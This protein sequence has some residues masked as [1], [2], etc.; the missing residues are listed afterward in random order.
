MN[1]WSPT[2]GLLFV[3]LLWGASFV[4]VKAALELAA[5]LA[6]LSVRFALASA[7]AL[8]LVRR[9]PGV[10][11]AFGWG[12]PL[13][14]VLAASYA[15]QTIGLVETSPSRSAF[16]TGAG[17]VAIP[18]WGLFLL[19]RRPA[20]HTL[21]GLAL[22]VY[23][24]WLIT[25][26]AG[27]SWDTG[28]SWTLACAILFSLHVVLLTRYGSHETFSLL[29]SQLLVTAILTGG[30]SYWLEPPPRI[31]WSGRLIAMIALTGIGVSFLATLLQIRLQSL[32]TPARTA[33][34]FATEPVFAALTSMLLL[35]ER[36]SWIG[37]I[38]GGLVVS[39]VLLSELGVKSVRPLPTIPESPA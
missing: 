24:I 38:G 4:V 21:L 39:G 37:W 29:T 6:F 13:G 11:A 34:V 25:D 18:L 20:P 28:D 32:L 12:V 7:F 1:R 17:V 2:A 5:P 36:M 8:L 15:A 33:V 23:G 27:G 30:L 3:S 10:R 22:A 14:A 35:G 31:A 16:I 19:G 26:P 9:R